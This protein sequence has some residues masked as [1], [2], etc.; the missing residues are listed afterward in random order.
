MQRT[1]DAVYVCRNS[2]YQKKRSLSGC[3][4]AHPPAAGRAQAPTMFDDTQGGQ[5]ANSFQCEKAS[6]NNADVPYATGY[7]P[8][9]PVAGRAHSCGVAHF[10]HADVFQVPASERWSS[11][12]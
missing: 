9:K 11:H 8:S 4:T 5:K 2:Y 6:S 7:S 12:S 10:I 3:P 1:T